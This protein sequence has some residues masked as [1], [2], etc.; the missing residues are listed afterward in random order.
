MM[1]ERPILMNG[2]MV[3]A[4]LRTVDPKTQTRRIVKP[5]KDRTIGCELR[6][7]EL[8][9]EINAGDYSNSVF[10]CP[11]DRL[12]V[13][14]THMNWWSLPPDG[15]GDRVFSHV[16]AFAADGYE[17]EP[18]EKWIP[19]IHML[20]AASRILLEIVSIRIERLNSISEADAKAEGIEDGGCMTCGESSHPAPCGCA[21]PDPSFKDA[22]V[23]LWDSINGHGA[24]H[25]NP[26]VWVVEFKRIDG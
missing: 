2:A 25:E 24:W 13:R 8:A 21:D 12:W 20:R 10:G 23:H 6:P 3:R 14:E 18:G 16:A 19:S 11:G 5:M 22:F 1:K 9:G 17:L 4:T 15:I 26:W 7:H